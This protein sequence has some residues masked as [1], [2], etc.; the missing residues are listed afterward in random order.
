[1]ITELVDKQQKKE[2]YTFFLIFSETP[3]LRNLYLLSSKFLSFCQFFFKNFLLCL[4]FTFLLLQ[5]I[6]LTIAFICCFIKMLVTKWNQQSS[7]RDKDLPWTRD[8]TRKGKHLWLIF[9]HAC[10]PKLSNSLSLSLVGMSS[11]FFLILI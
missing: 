4:F 5:I 11:M 9:Q 7:S 6:I 2:V 10:I 1:M 8:G 3:D